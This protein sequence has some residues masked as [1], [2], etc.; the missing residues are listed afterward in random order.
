MGALL[1]PVDRTKGG[2]KWGLVAYVT[3]MF[4]FA[5][6]YTGMSLDIQSISYVDYREFSGDDG[7]GD[8]GPLGYQTLVFSDAINVVPNTMFLLNNW[9]ADGFLVSFLLNLVAP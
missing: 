4:S 6:I 7:V 8:P 5:T 1:G 2:I 3:A 9:L